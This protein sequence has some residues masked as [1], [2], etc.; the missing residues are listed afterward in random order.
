MEDGPLCSSPICHSAGPIVKR[1]KLEVVKRLEFDADSE[2][3]D[4]PHSSPPSAGIT[5]PSSPRVPTEMW[6]DGCVLE[7]IRPWGLGVQGGSGW[8]PLMVA[9]MGF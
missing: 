9:G 1:L 7:A 2:M 8:T 5:P 3:E 6:G 4:P